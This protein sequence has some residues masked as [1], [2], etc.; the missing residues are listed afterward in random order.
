VQPLLEDNDYNVGD[1]VDS[2]QFYE[3]K[4][5]KLN[6]EV[7]VLQQRAKLRENDVDLSK[8]SAQCWIKKTLKFLPKYEQEK[9]GDKDATTADDESSFLS[10]LEQIDSEQESLIDTSDYEKDLVRYQFTRKYLVSLNNVF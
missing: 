6:E 7:R 8:K 9:S 2:I 1:E 4:L 5:E 10:T 3:T